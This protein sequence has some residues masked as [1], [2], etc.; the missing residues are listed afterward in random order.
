MGFAVG[1]NLLDFR[2]VR[3]VAG[4]VG[5]LEFGRIVALQPTGLVGDPGIAGRMG[6]VE[7]VLGEFLPVLPDL[8]QDLLRMTVRHAVGHELLLELHHHGYLLLSHRLAQLV[9]L[10][11]G[12]VGKLA[13]QK[14]DLLL[15]DCDS[16][17]L[18]EIFLHLR[19][20]IFNRL[21]AKF[22]GDE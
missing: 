2:H 20:V 7:G 4:E 17:G 15:V 6:L 14:H 18:G 8:V 3:K 9:R 5:R 1:E 19:K 22:P 21:I 11:L 10:A 13:A 12:E 16:V